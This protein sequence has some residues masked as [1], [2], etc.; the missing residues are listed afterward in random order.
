MNISTILNMRKIIFFVSISI[1]LATTFTSCGDPTEEND[2]VVTTNEQNIDSLLTNNPDDVH[3]LVQRGN[4]Y[5]DNYQ[6]DLAMNDAAKA[7]RLDSLNVSARLLYAEVLNNRENRSVEDV[8]I[9]QRHY[10]IVLGKQPEN[11]EALVGLASTYLFQQDFDRTF[12][13]VNDALRI[14]PK[15]RNAYVLK[16]T[17]YLM[18]DNKKLAI[19]SYETAIQQDPEFYEA[20]FIL[21]QIFQAENDP[22]CVE[23]FT[24]ASKLKPDNIEF[25]YQEAYSK[26]M[27]GQFEGAKENYREMAKSSDDVYIMRG[28]F[29]QGHIQQFEDKNIDSAIYFYQSAIKTD[30]RFLEAWFNLGICHEEKGHLEKAMKSYAKCL[31]IN[32]EFEAA[33]TRAN[34]I[35]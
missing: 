17:A 21:G 2:G 7:F 15:Y 13:F 11:T 25:K 33:K 10:K 4:E 31:E 28:L 24:S 1:F 22:L 23:Y 27:F 26:E 29:H 34:K 35:R 32:P 6:Y 8:S 16:G 9:A 5:F 18:K 30:P 3:L 14:D 19:S 12:Q 20:Y